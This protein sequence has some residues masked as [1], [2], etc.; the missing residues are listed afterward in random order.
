MTHSLNMTMDIKVISLHTEQ[1][2]PDYR[3]IINLYTVD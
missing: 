1:C 2:T 3:V